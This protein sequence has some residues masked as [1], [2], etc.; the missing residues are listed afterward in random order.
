MP[1]VLLE[2]NRLFGLPAHP[3]LVHG[4]VVLVPLAAGAFIVTGAREAWRRS[5]YLPVALAAIAGGVFAFL[6]K[7]SGE[8]LSQS[9]RRAGQHVG[10][11]PEN[12]DTAFFFA[13]L[14][15]G[16]VAAVYLFFRY[17]SSI[18]SA[19][20]IEGWPRLPISYNT[21]FY[22]AT[23]PLAVLA[24]FTMLVAGHSGAELVW[25]TNAG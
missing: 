6:A 17:E 18:R 14:F 25:K 21:A 4:A 20:R 11:H 23:I 2:I 12:G 1:L 10:E 16:A 19:L 7:Q 8:P 22:L 3:L 24:I 15:A 5:Y 13:V 9:V